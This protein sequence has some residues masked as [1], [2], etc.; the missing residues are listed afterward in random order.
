MHQHVLV[1]KHVDYKHI[2]V[3][4]SEGKEWLS[5]ALGRVNCLELAPGARVLTCDGGNS[6]E[7]HVIQ[8]WGAE[9]G[10]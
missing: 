2:F 4:Q 7:Q 9:C 6:L 10:V 8:R 1:L 5:V 3:Y